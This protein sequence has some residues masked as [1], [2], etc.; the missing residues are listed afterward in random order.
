[1]ERTEME[2]TKGTLQVVFLGRKKLHEDQWDRHRD[3][4]QTT[5]REV[6]N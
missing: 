3:H 6:A 4:T 1:M 2:K 5:E